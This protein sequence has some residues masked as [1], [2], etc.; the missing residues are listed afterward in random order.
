[1]VTG[2]KM[3]EKMWENLWKFQAKQ[4]EETK[5][6]KNKQQSSTLSMSSRGD[7]SNTSNL[8]RLFWERHLWN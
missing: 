5:A 1:M 4:E 8:C 3:W 6:L 7:T 2:Q